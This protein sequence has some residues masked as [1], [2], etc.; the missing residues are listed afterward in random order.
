MPEAFVC[1]K[2]TLNSSS[3]IL[4]ELRNCTEIKEAFKVIGEYDV[5]AKIEA[6][7]FEDL[8]K[9]D[10]C[11]KR[12]ANVREILSMLLI[13]DKKSAK[14]EINRITTILPK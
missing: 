3:E 9:L 13:E 7:T 4:K 1:I 11:I 6:T 2:T 8:V 12:R 5:I 14:K 10:Q